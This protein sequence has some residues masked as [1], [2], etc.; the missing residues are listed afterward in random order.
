MCDVRGRHTSACYHLLLTKLGIVLG[1]AECA[2][3][4]SGN[5]CAAKL[6]GVELFP[7]VLLAGGFE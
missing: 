4:E 3:N 7:D 5:L 1:L 6:G 2:L